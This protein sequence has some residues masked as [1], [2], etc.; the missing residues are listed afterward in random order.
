MSTGRAPPRS[1]SA[2]RGTSCSAPTCST[3]AATSLADQLCPAP[4]RCAAGCCCRPG[5]HA[6]RGVPR[7]L[8][9]PGG[10]RR[11]AGDELPVCDR[12][13]DG[14]DPPPRAAHR[15]QAVGK[16]IPLLGDG[17]DT[18]APTLQVRWHAGGRCRRAPTSPR[19]GP[20]PPC[21][22]ACSSSVDDVLLRRQRHGG[23]ITQLRLPRTAESSSAGLV[24]HRL[25]RLPALL[26]AA[27]PPAAASRLRAGRESRR[28]RPRFR[29]P[30]RGGSRSPTGSLSERPIERAVADTWATPSRALGLRSASNLRRRP[31]RRRQAPSARRRPRACGVRQAGHAGVGARGS[32]DLPALGR[33]AARRRLPERQDRVDRRLA[34]LRARGPA[35]RTR[36]NSPC[37][38]RLRHNGAMPRS[39]WSGA[40]SFGLVNVPVKL[41]SR[42]RGRPCASTSSTR[43]TGNR[44]EQKRV[45]SVDR[46]GGPLRAHRQGLRAHEG[47]LRRDHARRAR[48]ARPREDARRSTSRTS[49]T[50]TTSTRSTTTTRTTSCPTR[51]RRRPTGCCST[52][53]ASR[54][55]SRSPASC[56]A[57]RSSSSRSARAGDV[58]TMETMIFADEVVARR[59]RSTTLPEARSSR[60]PSASSRWPS[61]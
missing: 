41:Y 58:L 59:R 31:A 40:I 57:P 17:L 32:A 48:G 51:A 38:G 42:S 29:C 11:R 61:S 2:R 7:R 4:G 12:D 56:S 43:D 24:L 10:G 1:W 33:R 52:R 54:A 13:D 22:P 35:P 3:S 27:V 15:P 23:A 50:S 18:F 20:R 46:R 45:D 21:R 36:R 9:A 30:L 53:C 26:P 37:G 19:P 16:V 34:D 60:P 28:L 14:R 49:S 25:R 47:P 5:A 55:R 44:I 6:R 8:R 39:I